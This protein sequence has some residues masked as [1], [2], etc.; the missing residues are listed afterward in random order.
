MSRIHVSLAIS[1]RKTFQ[2]PLCRNFVTTGLLDIIESLQSQ[3]TCLNPQL[4][5]QKLVS[6]ISVTVTKYM[7]S[8]LRK[9]SFIL[10]HGLSVQFIMSKTTQQQEQET[11]GSIASAVRKQIHAGTQVTVSFG[12]CQNSHPEWDHL[13]PCFIFSSW[14]TQPQNSLTKI[15][16]SLSCR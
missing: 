10:A 8:D 12:F 6:Y 4:N 2:F 1:V 7:I 3:I 13:H 15:P 16:R 9:D 5:V 14:L 11:V